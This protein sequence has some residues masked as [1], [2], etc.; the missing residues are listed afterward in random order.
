[1]LEKKYLF[2]LKKKDNLTLRPQKNFFKNIYQWKCG[3]ANFTLIKN[4][5]TNTLI[6]IY[7]KIWKIHDECFKEIAV[8]LSYGRHNISKLV[9]EFGNTALQLYR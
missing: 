6:L 4:F 8:Q 3:N 1:M 2:N 5:R 7:E 9:K